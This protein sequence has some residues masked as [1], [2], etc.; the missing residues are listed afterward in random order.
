MVNRSYGGFLNIDRVAYQMHTTEFPTQNRPDNDLRHNAPWSLGN[1]SRDTIAWALGTAPASVTRQD[2]PTFDQIKASVGTRGCFFGSYF[3]N[4]GHAV[5]IDGFF[6]YTSPGGVA[7]VVYTQDPWNGPE[8]AYVYEYAFDGASVPYWNRRHSTRRFNRVWL[9]PTTGITPRSNELEVW[10]DSE[11]PFPDG[12]VDFDE[13]HPRPLQSDWQLVDTDSD[14][15]EDLAEVRSYTFHDRHHA[16]HENDALAF[17]DLDGDGR[18]SEADCDSDADRDFDGGEDIDGNGHN[19]DAAETCMFDA[20][21]SLIGVAVDKGV[22]QTLDPVI[23]AGIPVLGPG[24]TSTYH[25]NSTYHIEVG[26]GCPDRPEG[27]PLQH[28]GTFTTDGGG[29]ANATTVDVCLVPGVRHITIDVRGD[30]V[31]DGA[32]CPDFQTCWICARPQLTLFDAVCPF[33][34]LTLVDT[35]GNG[36]VEFPRGKTVFPCALVFDDE[37][38]IEFVET[39]LVEAPYVRVTPRAQLYGDP[40]RLRSLGLV[41]LQGDVTSQG[42]VDVQASDD[43]TLRALRGSLVLGEST[44]IVAADRL[45][46]EAKQGSIALAGPACDPEGPL[47]LVGGQRVDLTAKGAAGSVEVAGARIGGRRVTVDTRASV[48]R[49]DP[50]E[51]R[52]TDCAV[53]TTAPQRTGVAGSPGDVAVLATGSVFVEGGSVLD[54]GRNLKV[55]SRGPGAGLCLSGASTLRAQAPDGRAGRLD[56]RGVLGRVRDDATTTFVGQLLGTVEIG[57]CDLTPVPTTT[58]TT[59]LPATTIPSPTTTSSTLPP[60]PLVDAAWRFYVRIA[61]TGGGTTSVDVPRRS[62]DAPVPAQI[63]ESALPAFRIGSRVTGTEIAALGDDTLV[64]LTAAATDHLLAHPEDYP[65]F[66]SVVEVRSAVRVGP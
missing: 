31:V 54:S 19:P 50:K 44:R 17:P 59:V 27:T 26:P 39:T 33:F 10:G 16:G 64:R 51:V 4:P 65:D 14:Q 21:S 9:Q 55:T 48:S 28:T 42:T 3:G 43:V 34:S 8:Y 6:E 47:T 60:G 23:T 56:L 5:A 53:L 24:A 11:Q 57:P 49:V 32:G 52:I 38:P 62:T 37:T 12:I 22:Y 15:V 2:N 36:R 25:A 45:R 30:G 18:R 13:G 41:A 63:R 46:V 29:H 35:D 20:A 58:S 1:L 66:A 61:R 40:A 7:R